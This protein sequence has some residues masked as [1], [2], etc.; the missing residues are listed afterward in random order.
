MRDRFSIVFYTFAWCSIKKGVGCPTPFSFMMQF[1]D[2]LRP[3]SASI[4]YQQA[5]KMVKQRH[6]TASY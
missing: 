2:R 1:N 4:S 5:R 6:E 3:S